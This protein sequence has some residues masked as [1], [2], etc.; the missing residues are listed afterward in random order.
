MRYILT[1]ILL[2]SFASAATTQI[3]T[4]PSIKL[5]SLGSCDEYTDYF[6]Y[7]CMPFKC[8]LPIGNYKDV[9]REMEIIGEEDGKCIHNIK[10]VFDVS[11]DTEFP[12]DWP[13]FKIVP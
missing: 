4:A 11:Y 10:K 7:K 3:S 6:I 9:H 13:I 1:L 5:P 12:A 2:F 8:N